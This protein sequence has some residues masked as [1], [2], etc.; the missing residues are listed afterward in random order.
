MCCC[1]AVGSAVRRV[2]GQTSPPFA[3]PHGEGSLPTCVQH[4]REEATA[5]NS[6]AG[7][8]QA[9]A[10]LALLQQRHSGAHPGGGLFW[11]G[12]PVRALPASP[13][14]AAYGEH[15]GR[16]GELRWPGGDSG[17]L[18]AARGSPREAHGTAWSYAAGTHAGSR[19]ERKEGL[20]RRCL[21][22]MSRCPQ[23]GPLRVHLAGSPDP[24]PTLT[25]DPKAEASD[26]DDD[27]DGPKAKNGPS[28]KAKQSRRKASERPEVRRLAWTAEP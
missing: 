27:S 9:R 26:S 18:T 12:A 13:L 6:P 14:T 23:C 17:Q 8:G 20:R 19:T 2:Y 24:Q 10:A 1:S 16:A 3:V 4:T 21:C 7:A 28:G 11:H 5:H 22:R 15:G 25:Q